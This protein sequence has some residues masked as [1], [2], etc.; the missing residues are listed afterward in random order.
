[1]H[2]FV[3]EEVHAGATP[4]MLEIWARSWK[5]S[6]WETRI[7]TLSDAQSHPQYYWYLERFMELPTVNP[8]EY[9]LA[10]FLRHVAMAALGGGWMS[11]YDVLPHSL[12]ADSS[13]A[14]M[15]P[16]NFTTYELFVPSLVSG[17]GPEFERIARN[18]ALVPWADRPDIFSVHSKPHVSDM[19]VFKYGYEIQQKDATTE[20]HFTA[21][22]NK[23]VCKVL[24]VTKFV[25]YLHDKNIGNPFDGA[26]L[27][28]DNTCIPC[29]PR[30]DFD[31]CCGPL[32]VHF[33]HGDI[34]RVCRESSEESVLARNFL[35]ERFSHE[36]MPTIDLSSQCR[37]DF[38]SVRLAAMQ[39]LC[40]PICA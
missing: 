10:C 39:N 33:S 9:E 2:T 21:R 23:D 14:R 32:A 28:T 5:A 24:P 37:F 12:S 18:M 4:A 1:M 15:P 30:G 11:D 34:G 22:G 17:S 3:S 19:H 36:H 6:G 26:L 25:H 40:L 31:E 29:V 35:D 16:G 8:K 7:L 27:R 13:L 38:D 20:F